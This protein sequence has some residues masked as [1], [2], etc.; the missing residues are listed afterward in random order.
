MNHREGNQNVRKENEQIKAE[1]E[2]KKKQIQDLDIRMN[3]FEKYITSI[4]S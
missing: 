3:Y 4:T 1:N 2:N